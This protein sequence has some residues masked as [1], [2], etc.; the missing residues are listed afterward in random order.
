M[1][2]EPVRAGFS[3]VLRAIGEGNPTRAAALIVNGLAY[4]TNRAA[5]AF[6]ECPLDSST[7]ERGTAIEIVNRPPGR[8]PPFHA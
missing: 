3:R 5:L 7:V 8:E 2:P 4:K 6:A 1:T